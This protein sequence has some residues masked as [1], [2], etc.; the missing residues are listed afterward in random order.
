MSQRDDLM[1]KLQQILADYDIPPDDLRSRLYIALEP[2]EIT[3]RSTELVV[4]DEESI[5]KYVRRFLISKRVSGRTVRTLQAYETALKAFFRECP[6]IPT[7][8]NP[9][10]IKMFLA[11]KE[12][13]D[14]VGKVYQ[15][16]LFRCI[17][18][19]Y[20]WMTKEEYIA[21]NPFNKIESIKLPKAKKP[22]FTEM[23]IERLR[24]AIPPND[25]RLALAFELLLST[26]CRV[27]ELTCMKISEFSEN[28]ASVI[29]HGKGQ[30]DRTCY[31][32]ARTKL[33]LERYLNLR[34]D[35]ID[36]L[37]PSST[38]DAYGS[39]CISV[40]MKGTPQEE[41]VNWWQQKD[42]VKNQPLDKC[43]IESKIRKLG[44]AAGI[45]HTHPHRF[46]RTGA[47]F[48]LRRG[49]PIEQVSKLLGHESIETTQIYL[50]ISENELEQGHKKYVG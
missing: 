29:V 47:T 27:S 39:N 13:R 41:L 26:W 46:R 38:F 48:A 25:S 24:N 11:V 34:N 1:I 3:E 16:H 21:R 17:S 18:S 28:K 37:F 30:K 8:V 5:E 20:D 15:K 9:D 2:Y 7:E 19:F 31:L 4:A 6:K 35:S 50:D 23:D 22:A 36:W 33:A 45:E 42:F 43:S 49:M 32:N 44:K 12:V 10:D 40:A 14:G